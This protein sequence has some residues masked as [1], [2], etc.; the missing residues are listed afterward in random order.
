M[1][2]LLKSEAAKTVVSP[3]KAEALLSRPAPHTSLSSTLQDHTTALLDQ[4][5]QLLLKHNA[6][7]AFRLLG[8]PLS[9]LWSE[10]RGS[11]RADEM[12]AWCAHHA[13]FALVQQDPYTQ[14]AATKP[15][16]YAGDAVMMDY[17]YEGLAPAGTSSMGHAVFGATTR[18]PMGLSVLYRRQLLKS[19]IDDTVVNHEA[20]RVLSVASGH[21]RELQGSLVDAPFFS[22]EFVAL[23]QD[24]LSCAEVARAH[25]DPRVRVVHAGVRELMAG[26]LAAELG[27]FDLIYSAGLFDYLPDVLARRLT[28]QLLKMLR[29]GGRL[30]IAN[31]VPSGSGR[32]YMELFMDWTLVLRDQA[33]MLALASGVG[34]VT[35]NS[36]HDPHHNVV[37]AELRGAAVA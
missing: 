4:A 35:S 24:P 26:P 17:I 28:G 16:G 20:G 19:L 9:A 18:A 11:A 8:A 32:G 3:S 30:V 29:P 14:R 36:F 7:A 13:L 34:A 22:G 1:E 15:R 2:M 27:H 25:P 21:C 6:V 5:H 23:D 10:A 12:R 37:Y 31:F 33:A